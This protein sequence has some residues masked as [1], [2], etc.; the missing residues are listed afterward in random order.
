MAYKNDD[1]T[2][3]KVHEDEPIFVLRAQD[4]LA[5][6]LVD[7]WARRAEEAFVHPNKVA[8]AQSLAAAMRGWRRN[9]LTKL[10]D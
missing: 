10:P 6:P 4:I 5:A 8:G 9:H 2:L 1:S 3:A 7:E